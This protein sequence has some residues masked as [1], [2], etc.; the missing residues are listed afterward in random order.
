MYSMCPYLYFDYASKEWK[1]VYSPQNPQPMALYPLTENVANAE[2]LTTNRYYANATETNITFSGVDIAEITLQI[3]DIIYL[4]SGTPVVAEV[5]G[6]L[7]NSSNAS[8]GG[9]SDTSAVE[10]FFEAKTVEEEISLGSFTI[11]DVKNG[12]YVFVVD[13]QYGDYKRCCTLLADVVGNKRGYTMCGV[14]D[15]SRANLV[16]AFYFYVTATNTINGITNQVYSVTNNGGSSESITAK[17]VK[18]YKIR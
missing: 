8:G 10:V 1:E 18:A 14:Y 5:V 15:A 11:N 2:T 13:I 3:G 4:K 16:I 7:R 9:S 12:T 17:L 6:N